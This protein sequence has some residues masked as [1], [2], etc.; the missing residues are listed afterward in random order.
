[1][2]GDR[3]EGTARDRHPI[4]WSALH[5][6]GWTVVVDRVGRHWAV[7]VTEFAAAIADELQGGGLANGGA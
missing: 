1:M 6:N 7:N 5:R 2:S 4:P 3:L